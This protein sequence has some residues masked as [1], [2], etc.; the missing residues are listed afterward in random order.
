MAN[1]VIAIRGFD[2]Q[3]TIILAELFDHFETHGPSATVRPEGKDDLD[4]HWLEGLEPR[5]RH[6]QVKKPREDSDG[7]RKPAA[8]TLSEVISELLPGSIVRLSGRSIVLVSNRI[9]SRLDFWRCHL[10]PQH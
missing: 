9:E 8:W 5:S 6:I 4:L 1:G 3:S 7:N 2:Y 10:V